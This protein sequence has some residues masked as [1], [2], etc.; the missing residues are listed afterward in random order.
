MSL[1]RRMASSK[2]HSAVKLATTTDFF[3]NTVEKKRTVSD[4]QLAAASREGGEW[5]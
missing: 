4:L 2:R 1:T 5:E 3:C